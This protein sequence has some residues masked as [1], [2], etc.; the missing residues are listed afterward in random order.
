MSE[1]GDPFTN[2]LAIVVALSLTL[3][4]PILNI[5]ATRKVIMKLDGAAVPTWVLAIWLL[6]VVGFLSA[7]AAL[8]KENERE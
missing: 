2:L 6:P 4:V 1:S 3:A 5:V 7:F 8:S